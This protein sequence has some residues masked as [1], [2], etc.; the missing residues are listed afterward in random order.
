VLGQT[1]L[2]LIRLLNI[3]VPYLDPSI[4]IQRFARGLDFGKDTQKIAA[5]ATRIVQRM[6]RDWIVQGRRP[7]GI[8]GASLILA[9]RMNGHVRTVK[10]VMYVVKVA[11]ITIQKRLDD[12]KATSSSQLTVEQFRSV[13]LERAHDP[14]S[15]NAKKRKRK[16]GLDGEEVEEESSTVTDIPIDPALTTPQLNGT[17]GPV[18]TTPPAPINPLSPPPSHSPR[19]HQTPDDTAEEAIMTEISTELKSC[20]TPQI[21]AELSEAR[22]IEKERQLRESNPASPSSMHM[23]D[24]LILDDVDDDYDVKFALLSQQESKTKE[25]VWMEANAEYLELQEEKRKKKEM[26]EKNGVVKPTRK[27]RKGLNHAQ[28]VKAGI[29]QP[30]DIPSRSLTESIPA[31]PAESAKIML[32]KKGFSSKINYKALDHLFDD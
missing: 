32:M 28:M 5:D 22:R 9:A 25:K 12:F 6:E 31:S 8:C 16:R 23:N 26:D 19:P 11:D 7:S 13:W 1:F 29:I 15:F 17:S 4:Y 10:D 14:P 30:G 3:H 21:V 27:R 18:S 20:L 2:K 24:P